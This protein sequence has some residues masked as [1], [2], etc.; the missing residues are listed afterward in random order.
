MLGV[1]AGGNEDGGQGQKPAPPKVPRWGPV[2]VPRPQGGGKSRPVD[3][4][5]AVGQDGKG[6]S[7]DRWPGLTPPLPLLRRTHIHTRTP[8]HSETHSH[9]QNVLPPLMVRWFVKC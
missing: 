9:T 3:R 6:E 7:R 1:A 8:T 2:D 5:G 4:E